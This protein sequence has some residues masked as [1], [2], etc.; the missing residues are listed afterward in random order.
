MTHHYT[1]CS[2][3][4]GPLSLCARC[5]TGKF[6]SSA[7]SVKFPFYMSLQNLPLILTPTI[8]VFAV[9]FH[10]GFHQFRLI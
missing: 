3:D 9:G 4:K 5:N 10:L 6:L 1:L 2:L 8:S 7:I